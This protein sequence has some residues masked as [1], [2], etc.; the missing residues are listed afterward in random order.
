MLQLSRLL[1]FYKTILPFEF[2]LLAKSEGIFWKTLASR[3]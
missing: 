1:N 3:I 2:D